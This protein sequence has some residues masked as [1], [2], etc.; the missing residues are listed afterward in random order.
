M[1][2]R[3]PQR[4][5]AWAPPRGARLSDDVLRRSLHVWPSGGRRCMSRLP[6][7][8]VG[9]ITAEADATALV[10]GLMAALEACGQHVQMFR[11]R[12]CFAAL[13]GATVI[14]GRA[15]RHLDSW[16][17]TP[18]ACRQALLRGTAEGHLALVE[19]T[20][21]SAGAS[22]QTAPAAGGQLDVALRLARFAPVG[23]G[24]RDA[25]ATACRLPQ[26][27]AAD[28]LLLDRISSEAG[29]YRCQTLL[30]SLWGIP[31]LGRHGRG[32]GAAR[33]NRRA[34]PGGKA[35]ALAGR[36]AGQR[37]GAHERR[38]S[39]SSVG[40]RSSVFLS[41]GAGR[42]PPGR[43][44]RRCAWPSLGT[45]P[46]TVII[47]ETL[48]LL[49]SRGAT[50]C[51]FS[52]LGDERLPGGHRHRLFRLRPSRAFR[53]SVV[54]EP[55]PG[56]G[57]AATCLQR[58]AALRRR[59]WTGLFVRA[60][61]VGRRPAVCHGRSSAGHRPRESPTSRSGSARAGAAASELARIGR[62][63]LAWLPERSVDDRA[64]R[65]AARRRRMRAAS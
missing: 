36:S 12:A 43:I 5:I 9:T 32:R 40:R 20:F 64:D 24:R 65:S 14:S 47:P 30:E 53:P 23:S 38:R 48:E 54:R 46:S 22:S 29:F 45:M 1:L 6:R 2:A 33:G 56:G 13:D 7:V 42:E 4:R 51:D 41:A 26:R 55:M 37:P 49:E 60:D 17:M 8:A 63:A 25:A 28:G 19:G 39:H 21:G 58:P 27:P 11:A 10:W 31:V 44:G 57:T 50:L 15:T 18:D 62:H 35:A 59:G 16:L 61:R 52:P 3:S 34:G